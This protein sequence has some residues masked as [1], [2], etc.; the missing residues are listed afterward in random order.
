MSKR[1]HVPTV[2]RIVTCFAE[3]GGGVER[4]RIHSSVDHESLDLPSCP[5]GAKWRTWD[6]FTCKE[7][8]ASYI[9][10]WIASEEAHDFESKPDA[11]SSWLAGWPK[12]MQAKRFQLLSGL[13]VSFTSSGTGL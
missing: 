3:G 12:A 9:Y 1:Y 8:G 11:V 13:G 2:Y 10:A 6:V 7:R 5:F 4:T